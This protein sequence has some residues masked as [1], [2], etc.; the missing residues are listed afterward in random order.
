MKNTKLEKW[1]NE[2]GIAQEKDFITLF[3]K[4]AS[5]YKKR[6]GVKNLKDIYSMLNINP[7]TISKW[8]YNSTSTQSRENFKADFIKKSAG[9]FSLT[10]SETEELAN[11][12]GLSFIEVSEG[13]TFNSSF[14]E[15]FRKLVADYQGKKIDLCIEATVSGRMFRHLQNGRFLRKESILAL[16]IVMGLDFEEIQH[17][18]KKAGFILSDSMSNDIV[19][20]WLL[21]NKEY[22]KKGS[23]RLSIINNVLYESDLPLL[24]TR[25]RE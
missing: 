1:L 17:T 23:E 16:L 18:L 4:Y 13:K 9:L 6:N 21:K 14:A 5:E 7:Q 25:Y 12:A 19:I 2:R 24:I 15:Y 3:F 10:S 20:I 8:R 11:K 22:S